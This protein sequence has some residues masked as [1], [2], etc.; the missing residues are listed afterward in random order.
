M[1]SWRDLLS[2][3][4][5]I[6]RAW[7]NTLDCEFKCVGTFLLHNHIGCCK[8]DTL[9]LIGVEDRGRDDGLSRLYDRFTKSL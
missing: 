1:D 2:G 6:L 7:E 3:T 4:S 9:N 8:D 5:T